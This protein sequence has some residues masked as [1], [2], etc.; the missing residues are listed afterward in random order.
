MPAP[1]EVGDRLRVVRGIEVLREHE[2]EHQPEPDGH[3]RVP[4]EVE[5]DLESVSRSAEPGVEGPERPCVER[6]IGDPAARIGEEHLLGKSQADERNAAG[7]LRYGVGP[8]RE[9]FGDFRK[10]DD[11]PGDELGKHRHVAPEV[12]EVAQRLRVTAGDV[13]RVADRLEGVE[14]DA[15]R[16][17]HPQRHVEMKPRHVEP[18]SDAVHG[19]HTEVEVLE[20][21][22]QHQVGRQRQGDRQ[23]P[24]AGP[25]RVAWVHQADGARPARRDL[26]PTGQPREPDRPAA[27][28][29]QAAHVVDRRGREQQYD[30]ERIRPPVEQITEQGQ[31]QVPGAVRQSVVDDQGDWQEAEEEDMRAEDHA[32]R[33]VYRSR[34]RAGTPRRQNG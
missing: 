27:G 4:A 29:R 5:I 26:P 13:Y 33:S 23:A 21:A 25:G 19:V 12:Y 22:E 24:P 3:V 28:K 15:Q 30:E 1:P 6:Q 31:R 9:L 7:A 11:R 14:A 16:K 34:A 10:A 17:S 32:T 2:A 8:E 20:E 18:G